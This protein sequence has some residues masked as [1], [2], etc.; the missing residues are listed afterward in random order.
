MRR[1]RAAPSRRDGRH[2]RGVDV[3]GPDADRRRVLPPHPQHRHGRAVL[4]PREPGRG[5]SDL[6]H[7]GSNEHAQRQCQSILALVFVARRWASRSGRPAGPRTP[8]A[9]A[10]RQAIRSAIDSGSV[11]AIQA[12]L[13]HAEH[14]VCGG[15]HRHGEAADR[16]PRLPG[17]PGRGLVAGAAR[18]S[19]AACYV[20][21][22]TR[23]SQP[24]SRRRA[25]PPTCWASSVRVGDPGAGRGAVEP[26]LHGRGAGGHG[27]RAR[28]RSAGR[29][30]R[31]R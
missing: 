17:A 28:H 20:E 3:G 11:D 16:P 21:M 19:P 15:L 23:L 7:D 29:R 22:L 13:E 6:L 14:L 24:D 12:E 27:A 1:E 18:R 5:R 4:L 31:R 30:R 9:A 10:A 2:P 8:A 25:T 26:H